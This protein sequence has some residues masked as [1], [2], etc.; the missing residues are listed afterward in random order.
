MYKIEFVWMFE[1]YYI[2]IDVLKCENLGIFVYSEVFL[3]LRKIC[4]SLYLIEWII[5]RIGGVYW[6]VLGIY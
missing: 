2:L 5:K 3:R 1:C 4:Y 6:F